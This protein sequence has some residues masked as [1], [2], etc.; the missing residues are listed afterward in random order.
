MRLATLSHK[1]NT[2][3]DKDLTEYNQLKNEIKDY[4]KNLN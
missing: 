4:F 2:T 1:Y 3:Q